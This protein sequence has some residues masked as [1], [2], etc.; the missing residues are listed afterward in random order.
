MQGNNKLTY[1]MMAGNLDTILP[2]EEK[3][4]AYKIF[5]GPKN[6]RELRQIG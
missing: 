1:T 3:N 4:Y 6:I 5:Y 2:G